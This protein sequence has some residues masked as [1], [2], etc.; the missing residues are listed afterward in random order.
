MQISL[1]TEKLKQRGQNLFFAFEAVYAKLQI[2]L[3]LLA[4][5]RRALFVTS[6]KH[7]DNGIFKV[8][9]NLMVPSPSGAWN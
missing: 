4:Q 5:K 3:R 7:F 2:N 6:C 9:R 1:F 8:P